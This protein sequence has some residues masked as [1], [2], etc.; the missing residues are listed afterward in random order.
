MKYHAILLLLFLFF[1][2]HSCKVDKSPIGIAQDSTGNADDST[3]NGGIDTT[4]FVDDSL[5]T[6]PNGLIPTATGNSWIYAD[7][8]WK[9]SG[10]TTE[11]DSVSIIGVELI[12]DQPW[13]HLS[14]YS[15]TTILISPKFMIENDTIYHMETFYPA[16]NAPAIQFIPP[17][18]TAVTYTTLLGGDVLYTRTV[19]KLTDPFITPAGIFND[20]VKYIH[21]DYSGEADNICV[22]CPGVGIVYRL[23]VFN[24][25]NQF[26]HSSTLVEFQIE[27]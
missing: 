17:Q 10:L 13:W 3:G 23:I 12:N 21:Y 26:I 8:L 15:L 16:G 19:Y 18:D 25:W 6:N 14:G 22:I 5:Y 11:F 1:V 20:C 4:Q 9:S 24:A 27:E 2:A 7:S